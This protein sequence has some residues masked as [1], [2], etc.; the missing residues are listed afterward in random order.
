[1]PCTRSPARLGHRDSSRQRFSPGAVSR[2]RLAPGHTRPL[3]A[4]CTSLG[5]NAVDRLL[6][7]MRSVGT[8][9]W[10]SVLARDLAATSHGASEVIADH[11]AASG[12]TIPVREPRAGRQAQVEEPN[13]KVKSCP[14]LNIAGHPRHQRART[15]RVESPCRHRVDRRT[16]IR[17]RVREETPPSDW[18]GCLPPPES[19]PTRELLLRTTATE[20][21]FR[22]LNSAP[23]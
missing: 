14:S 20:S 6:Q 3:V 2:C 21:P 11:K 10:P 17:Q 4:A 8:P 7:P 15:G 16:A 19:Q 18:S 9:A 12:T 1:M 22:C 13:P 5:F 23:N